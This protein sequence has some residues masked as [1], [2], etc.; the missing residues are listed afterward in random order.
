VV[1]VLLAMAVNAVV[2]NPAWDWPTVG[3]FLFAP[4]ILRAVALTLQ[5]TVL[6]IVIG[7]VIGTVLAVMRLSPNPCCAPPAGPTSGSSGRCR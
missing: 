6:R 5:L 3:Q 4:S 2:T 1:T 7:F